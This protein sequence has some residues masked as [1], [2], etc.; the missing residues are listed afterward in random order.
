[1]PILAPSGCFRPWVAR[2][3]WCTCAVL[4][5]LIAAFGRIA[6]TL[7]DWQLV[8]IGEGD[9]RAALQAQVERLGLSESIRLP[10]L[11]GN[12]ADWYQRADLFVLSSRFE[13]FPNAL[14][15]AMAQLQALERLRKN[16]K[17]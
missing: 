6:S 12:L 15:E 14:A 17:H 4:P 16:L 8:I 13:G 11:A 3:R 1:M 5:V 9:E 2:A 10:G 7:P